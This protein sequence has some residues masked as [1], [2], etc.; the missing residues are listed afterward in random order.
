M[1]KKTDYLTSSIWYKLVITDP[2][3]IIAEY[4]STYNVSYVRKT[5]RQIIRS[6]YSNN[7]WDKGTPEHLLFDFE[8]LE[9][10][11]NACFLINLEKKHS[12]IQ[13]NE[14]NLFNRNLF[15]SWHAN[16]TDWDEVPKFLSIR[17]YHDP[18]LGIT[19]FFRYK[20]IH[21]WKELLNKIL[22]YAFS[23]GSIRAE[24]ADFDT[25]AVLGKLTKLIEATHLI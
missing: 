14:E 20:N 12:P 23:S 3:Q 15:R 21:E 16:Y 8:K 1:K 17:E 18:Y 19:R 6:A 9:S 25:L 2:Y 24:V 10:V 7:V 13:V 5:I 4:Y 22:R 11:V